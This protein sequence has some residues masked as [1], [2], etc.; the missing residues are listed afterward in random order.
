MIDGW[1]GKLS[2]GSTVY[3][4]FGWTPWFHKTFPN[5]QLVEGVIA[6]FG[7]DGRFTG[8]VI[9]ELDNTSIGILVYPDAIEVII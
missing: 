2:D 4:T 6:G 5:S 9:V 8:E 7:S 1:Y 3:E